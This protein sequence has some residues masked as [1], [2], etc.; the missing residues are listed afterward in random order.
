MRRNVLENNTK[1]EVGGTVDASI[2]ENNVVR[3]ADE[4]IKI[5]KGPKNLLL[6]KNRLEKVDK[7]TSGEGLPQAQVLSQQTQGPLP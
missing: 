7:P 2:V 5:T 6:R 1:I 3:N 4:G